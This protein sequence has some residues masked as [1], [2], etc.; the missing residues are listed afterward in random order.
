MGI[1]F[2]KDFLTYWRDRK[3]LLIAILMP[4]VL[5]FVMSFALPNW[6]GN[7][8]PSIH[9]K[10]GFV[11]ED[12]AASG[13]A[14]FKESLGGSGRT[15]GEIAA[16][17][18]AADDLNPVLLLRGLLDSEE[19]RGIAEVVETDAAAALG[20]LE[21]GKWT[22]IV[23]IPAG[24]TQL[25]LGGMLLGQEETVPLRITAEETSME[26]DVL[27]DVLGDYYRSLNFSMAIDTVTK[28]SGFVP[29]GGV[30]AALAPIGGIE[31]VEGFR[32]I[33]SSQYFT[34][35]MSVLFSMFMAMTT[36]TKA[37]TEKR[38]QV[39][40]RILLS[41]ARPVQYVAGKAMSTFC[42]TMLQA[43]IAFLVCHFV[44]NLF[45]GESLSFWFGVSAL[46]TVYCIGMAGLAT[47]FTSI[48]FRLK[49]DSASGLMMI[50]VMVFGTLG[51]GFVPVYVLPDW[52]RGIGEWTPNGMALAAYT[53]WIQQGIVPDLYK[54]T[55]LLLIFSVAAI[56]VGIAMFPRKGRI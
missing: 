26:L 41:G 2:R 10:I 16:L 56:I 27:R 53:D 32:V 34:L 52:M 4:L 40:Q 38:E 43:V 19:F 12:D 30:D 48:T 45:P 44:L 42:M 8:T 15:E 17:A 39:F 24:Y 33:T 51:G 13:I 18:A 3:E 49:E 9:M 23:T 14:A 21:N 5:I 46:L 36:A 50:V 35:S 54:S 11:V 1:F 31:Q 22:A 7:E 20:Q 6:F 47:I 28:A 55:A 37:M 25:G 29:T